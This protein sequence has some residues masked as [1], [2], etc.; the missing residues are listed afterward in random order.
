MAN[1]I[2]YRTEDEVRD[3]A[4]IQLGFDKIEAN[5]K[6]GTGQI[7]T[8]NQLGFKGVID[9]PD[10][11]YLPDDCSIPAI[12]LETKS[13]AEDISLQKWADELIKNCDI[14][15]KKYKN[16]CGILYN[17]IDIRVFKNGTEVCNTEISNV[18]QNKSYYLAL[19]T[20]DNIDKQQIYNLTK[21]I[22]DCLH[23]EFGIKNLYNRMIFTACALV[24]KR[25]GAS[26]DVNVLYPKFEMNR[27]MAF[28][29]IPL[30]KTAGKRY[31]FID[32]WKKEDM[33]KSKI[34]LPVDKDGNPDYKY[35]ENHIVN[36][37]DMIKIYLTNL[38]TSI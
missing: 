21:R 32:K 7:T 34:P 5:V 4:K 12:I 19:F 16:T 8:F 37:F 20:Q 26:D 2:V 23:T 17:G 22:N 25:Y 6:Q 18:L 14:V 11:W 13:E 38:V 3:S 9:K 35:M 10:G 1:K 31:A 30:L 27:E 36:K 33:E 29:I 15:S 28:F 24:A